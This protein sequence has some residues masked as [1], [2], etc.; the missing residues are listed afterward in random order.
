MAALPSP[1]API[2]VSPS[3]NQAMLPG[4]NALIIQFSCPVA[5]GSGFVSITRASGSPFAS[6]P[7]QS[8]YVLIQP[9]DTAVITLPPSSPL[10]VGDFMVSIGTG[11][12]VD[13]SRASSPVAA[14]NFTKFGGSLFQWPIKGPARSFH[15][16]LSKAKVLS[17]SRSTRC[18]FN[19]LALCSKTPSHTQLAITGSTLC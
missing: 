13:L 10:D 7:V 4:T 3:P 6:I 2:Y 19:F 12:F 9:S 11:L 16:F 17:V 5:V 18:G 8:S 1:C 14:I 15:S